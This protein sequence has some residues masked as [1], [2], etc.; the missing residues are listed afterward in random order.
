MSKR[1]ISACCAVCLGAAVATCTLA[2]CSASYEGTGSKDAASAEQLAQHM[3]DPWDAPIDVDASKVSATPL[4]DGVYEGEGLGMAGVIGVKIQVKDNRITCL[5]VTQDGESQSVGGYEAVRDG[6]YAALIDAAQGADID[7]VS[8]ATITTAGVKAAVADAL[9]KAQ[10]A[11]G[12]SG[13]N[14]G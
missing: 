9:A 3:D 5:E 2:G 6:T 7:T 11:D 8:G 14:Q 12:A 4:A 10:V 1:M 13:G